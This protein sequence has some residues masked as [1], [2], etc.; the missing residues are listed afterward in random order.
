MTSKGLITINEL[1]VIKQTQN[2][3]EL[4]MFLILFQ[5]YKG[6]FHFTLYHN[7]PKM[8]ENGGYILCTE[9]SMFSQYLCS[10]I[11]C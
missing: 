7:F 4:N 10:L 3:P 11:I 9:N 6:A 5:I 1:M 8:K 2:I